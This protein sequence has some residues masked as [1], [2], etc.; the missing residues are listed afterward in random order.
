[1]TVPIGVGF[2][3]IARTTFDIPLAEHM[4]AQARAQLEAAG[5]TLFGPEA[6]VTNAEEAEA[7]VG[8]LTEYS[9]PLV[10]VFQ[11][12][13]ADSTMVT[14]IAQ[15]VNAPLLMWAVPEERTGGRLRLNSL[16]GINLAAHALKR[17]GY[18][19]EHVYAAPGDAVVVQKALALRGASVARRWLQ[20]SRI[21]R[22]GENP[23]GFETC[24][25]DASALKERFGVNIVQL[26]L[27]SVFE[28][29]RQIEPDT[30]QL[31]RGELAER[32]SGLESVNQ[33]ALDGTLSV[34]WT[35]R[36]LAHT[37][38]LEGFAV[39]CWPEF[40]TERGCAACG[41][42]S[43]MNDG[44]V[45]C[46]CEA[47]VNGT[48]TQYILQ[49]ISGE[50]AF[51]TDVVAV[52][53]ERDG[54]VLWHCGLAPLSMAD[55]ESQPV[56]AIHS[57][58]KLPLLME[59]PLKPGRVTVARLSEAGGEYRLV[60]GAGEMQRAP[61]S[62]SGTSGVVKFDRPAAEVLD[63]LLSEGLEHH[64]SLTYGDHTNALYTL[65]KML[66]L[67]VLRL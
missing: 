31:T 25:F 8:S 58:R 23:A 17:A 51:G 5:F 36:T 38:N 21:G 9:P 12:T 35:L 50:P 34:Y 26:D 19:Y 24:N 7:A 13:F 66:E 54:L 20:G 27:G 41:A 32:V 30:I 59:F 52:D 22:V 42:M 43:M 62:F 55:P 29:S 1:M 48:I 60:V 37:Q 49:S 11:A 64:L 4:T 28:V 56:A 47:D 33:T 14:S 67:P 53:D 57:N 3:A 16:C 2:I 46:S 44:G 40:F 6:L 10:I 65:A 61:K 63:T 18:F 45:P 39:R 15:A